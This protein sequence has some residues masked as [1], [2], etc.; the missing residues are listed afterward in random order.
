MLVLLML[1]DPID[2]DEADMEI[3]LAVEYIEDRLLDGADM[4]NVVPA[5]V[6][7]LMAYADDNGAS[8]VLH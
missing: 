7:I 1:P 8:E 3:D 5:L 4:R 6:S 2:G